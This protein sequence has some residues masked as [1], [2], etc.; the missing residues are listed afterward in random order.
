[1]LEQGLV[2]VGHRDADHHRRSDLGLTALKSAQL[3]P[4]HIRELPDLDPRLAGHLAIQLPCEL[5]PLAIPVAVL[6]PAERHGENDLPILI[7]DF[8]G[9]AG[10]VVARD[11]YALGGKLL[12]IEIAGDLAVFHAERVGFAVFAGLGDDRGLA[13][14][15]LV[16]LA[17][18]RAFAT[19]TLT[20]GL[21]VKGLIEAPFELALRG[22][23]PAL[24]LTGQRG[25]DH[26][27]QGQPGRQEDAGGGAGGAGGAARAG[28]EIGRRLHRCTP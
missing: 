24:V 3:L 15:A 13:A 19:G 23:L 28:I 17:A 7:D 18:L 2:G 22:L 20:L 1:M 8:R 14:L 11:A 16:R 6:S 12:A 25:G 9:L 4:A 21:T 5:L 10:G 27:A 26:G